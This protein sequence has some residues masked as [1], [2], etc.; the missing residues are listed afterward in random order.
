[1]SIIGLD[2]RL[3]LERPS[4]IIKTIDVPVHWTMY[5]SQQG[6][7]RLT[8]RPRRNRRHFSDDIFNFI[9]LNENVCNFD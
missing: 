5:G 8:L 1:M 7:G 6:L 2:N 4:A 3:L 9:F